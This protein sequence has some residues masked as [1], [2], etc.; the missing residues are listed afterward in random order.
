MPPLCGFFCIQVEVLL[1]PE[2]LRFSPLFSVILKVIWILIVENL[3]PS[4]KG[5]F[6]P[7]KFNKKSIKLR[8][9][10]PL[11]DG[12]ERGQNTIKPRCYVPHKSPPGQICCF[13]HLVPLGLLPYCF[14][15][16]PSRALRQS[17]GP[18]QAADS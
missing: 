5:G 8:A 16:L 12:G 11:G 4:L 13:L 9:D 6:S 1:I 15:L 10:S 2:I 17:Q 14:L 3:A 18:P 7:L